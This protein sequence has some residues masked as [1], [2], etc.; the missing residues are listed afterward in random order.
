MIDEVKISESKILKT[1]H[2]LSQNSQKSKNNSDADSLRLRLKTRF[3]CNL[4][5][6]DLVQTN[7][8]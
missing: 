2:S 6:L 8:V 7:R 4:H 5:L 1:L 3:K